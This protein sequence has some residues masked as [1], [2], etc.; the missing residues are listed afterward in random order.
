[1]PSIDVLVATNMISVGVDVPRLGTMVV[2]GR[3]SGRRAQA[4]R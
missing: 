3:V 1:V 4:R 2:A